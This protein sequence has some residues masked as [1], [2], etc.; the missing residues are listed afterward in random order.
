[1]K[2]LGVS[3]VI[4]RTQCSLWNSW[5]RE[6]VLADSGSIPTAHASRGWDAFD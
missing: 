3:G 5:E 6:Q 1:M 2:N 4:P